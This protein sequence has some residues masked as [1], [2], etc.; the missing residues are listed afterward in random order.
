MIV[1]PFSPDDAGAV[2]SLFGET[3]RAVNA[4]DYSA[5]QVAAWAAGGADPA[6]WAARLAGR[7][8]FVAVARGEVVGFADVTREGYFDH[9]YVHRDHQGEGIGSALAAAVESAAR[10]LGVAEVT[11]EASITARPFFARRGYVVLREQDK[12]AHGLV[13]RNYVMRKGMGAGKGQG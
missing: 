9:L 5:E 1:R 4:R 2:A 10:A 13:Y 6:R 7:S 3:V 8:A 12:P 11:T